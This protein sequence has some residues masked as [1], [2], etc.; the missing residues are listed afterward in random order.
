[1]QNLPFVRRSVGAF[2]DDDPYAV[3]IGPPVYRK[4]AIRTRELSEISSG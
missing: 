1:M 2:E 3:T 4:I